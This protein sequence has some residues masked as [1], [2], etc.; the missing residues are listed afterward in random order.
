MKR[1]LFGAALAA[2]L[3][4]ST[5]ADAFPVHRRMFR[6]TYDQ[7]VRCELCHQRGG[8][9]RRNLFGDAWM[10]AG[11]NLD[12]FRKIESADSDGDG[13]VNIVEIQGGSNPGD[14]KSTPDNPGRRWKS[15]QRVPIPSSQLELAFGHV[16]KI[17]AVEIDLTKDRA[18]KATQLLGRELREEERFP[19]LYFAIEGGRRTAVAVFGHRQE[20]SGRYTVLVA[21]TAKAQ[22]A[23][24]AIFRGGKTDGTEL[25]PYAKCLEGH[26]ARDL[27]NPGQGNCPRV[28]GAEPVRA[29]VEAA[30]VIASVSLSK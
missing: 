15:S 30:L 25:L 22:V 9:N 27:P 26:S 19:T 21:L 4:S 28:A 11:E 10:S 3:T 1:L 17:E 6:A 20:A 29:A 12:A 2:L 5:T 14:P 24:I 13:V 7:S 8:G 16:E 18:A 23:K